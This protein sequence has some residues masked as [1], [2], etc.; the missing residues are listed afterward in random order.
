MKLLR[1]L[2]KIVTTLKGFAYF[3][4]KNKVHNTVKIKHK[5]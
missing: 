2:N 1:F 4:V 3:S 5:G